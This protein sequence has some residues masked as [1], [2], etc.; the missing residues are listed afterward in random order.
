MNHDNVKHDNANHDKARDTPT[1]VITGGSAGLGLALA[2]SL[3]AVGWHVIVTG[4][5]A[6]RLADAAGPGITTVAGD[7]TDPV[8]RRQLAAIV[9][10]GV[11][12][13]VNNASSLGPSPMP[14]LSRY[15]LDRLTEVYDTNVVA[16]LALLQELLPLLRSRHGMAVNITSD[17]AVQPYEGWGGYGSS[18]AA[19]DHLSAILAAEE[20]DIPIYA[21]DPGDMRTA[22]HQAAFPSEDIS[23]RPDPETVVPAL[24]RLIE[25]RP[26]SGRYIGST[27]SAE[28][29][30]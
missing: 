6:A 24:M 30:A 18:K 2:R 19:L 21:F 23:D 3:A 16:P 10:D 22:M 11:E 8:H 29:P 9:R 12:L 17:A 27:L 5:D 26:P 14:R 1:A 28:V 25:A 13:L 4:R 15:P 7:V 20:P